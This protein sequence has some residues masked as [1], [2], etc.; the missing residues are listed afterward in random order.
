[1]QSEKGAKDLTMHGLY[2]AGA[3]KPY[4]VGGASIRTLAHVHTVD[5]S[6]LITGEDEGS[7]S[8]RRLWDAAAPAHSVTAQTAG[9]VRQQTHSAAPNR[10]TGRGQRLGTQCAFKGVV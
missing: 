10:S 7:D 3:D 5:L 4:L 2:K 9:G 8:G 6:P 1:M